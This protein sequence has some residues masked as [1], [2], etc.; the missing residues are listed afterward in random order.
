MRRLLLAVVLILFSTSAALAAE[1]RIDDVRVRYGSGLTASFVVKGAFT[2]DI[3]EAI[4]SG[5][6]TTFT[7]I[8]KL[9][10]KNVLWPDEHMG[11]WSFNHTVKYDALKQ[12]YVV[13][14]EEKN[15]REKTKDFERMKTLMVT[16]DEII[17]SPLPALKKGETYELK[18]KAELDTVDLPFLLKYMFFFVKLWDFETNWYVYRLSL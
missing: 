5:L 2:K 12:E 17:I 4:N 3:E 16:G 15:R 14:I 18:L 11:T 6:P 9:Y 1:A 8:V 10:R 7:F 13:D